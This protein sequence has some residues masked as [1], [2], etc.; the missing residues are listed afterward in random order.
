MF[1]DNLQEGII[2]FLISTH[3]FRHSFATA[4]LE[5]NADIR[6]IQNS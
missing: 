3:V 1:L 4:M 2:K 5:N 6:H